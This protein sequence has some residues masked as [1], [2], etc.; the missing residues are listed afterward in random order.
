[1]NFLFKS[2]GSASR[3]PGLEFRFL[4]LLKESPLGGQPNLLCQFLF[5]RE[6]V[7][8]IVRVKFANMWKALRTRPAT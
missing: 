2:A 6:R 7:F 8:S 4:H 5:L 1:M 3:L